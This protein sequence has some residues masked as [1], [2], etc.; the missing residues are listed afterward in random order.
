V[1]DFREIFKECNYGINRYKQGMPVHNGINKA[2]LYT[3]S[4]HICNNLKTNC[5]SY[6]LKRLFHLSPI[7]LVIFKNMCVCA[8]KHTQ[9]SRQWRQQQTYSRSH[10]SLQQQHSVTAD[11]LWLISYNTLLPPKETIILHQNMFTRNAAYL[12]SQL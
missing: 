7:V 6:P 10:C 5:Q 9:I 1:F 8:H 3:N 2:C 4:A 12:F 11:F